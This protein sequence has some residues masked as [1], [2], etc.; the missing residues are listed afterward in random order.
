MLRRRERSRFPE[1][2]EPMEG[3]ANLVD[4]ML[5]FACGLMVALV[6]SWHLQDL[7]FSRLSPGEKQQLLRALGKMVTLEQGRELQ[8]RPPLGSSSGSGYQEV[9]T[10]YRDPR[11]GKLIMIER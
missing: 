2:A 10:V 1:P 9:G 6:L 8:E 5:V 3:V 11:T 7:V 4:A